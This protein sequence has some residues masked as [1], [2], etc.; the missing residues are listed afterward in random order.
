MRSENPIAGF[1]VLKST[2]NQNWKKIASVGAIVRSA[3]NDYSYTDIDAEKGVSYYRIRVNYATADNMYR[4][5][6]VKSIRIDHKGAGL[7][8]QPNP[9]INKASLQ[10]SA[11]RNTNVSVDVLDVN[12]KIVMQLSRQVSQGINTI[13]LDRVATLPAGIY[14]IRASVDGEILTTKF[15]KSQQ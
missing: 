11:P 6:E 3:N 2:D 1:E 15:I 13:Q 4:F 12:G 10:L 5:S 14:T 7:R 9:V 8:I